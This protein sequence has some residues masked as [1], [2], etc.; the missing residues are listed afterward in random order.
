MIDE[1]N[2]EIVNDMSKIKVVLP[3]HVDGN[4]MTLTTK[5]AFV[6]A[7]NILVELRLHNGY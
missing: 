4:I 1:D 2:T 5:E 7:S 6:L 3:K